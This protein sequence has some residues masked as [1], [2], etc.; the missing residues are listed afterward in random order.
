MLVVL[1][2]LPMPSIGVQVEQGDKIGHVLAYFTLM[3]WY[4]QLC[5]TRGALLKRALAVLLLGAL[6]EFAQ[7][8]T[9]WRAG[10]DPWDMLANTTGV[11]TACLVALTPLGRVLAWIEERWRQ[12][13]TARA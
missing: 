13:A 10:N 9:P 7:S 3:F 4:A 8:F 12:R 11:V 1:S 5:A 2:L 6:M